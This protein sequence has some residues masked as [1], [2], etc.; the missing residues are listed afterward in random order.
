MQLILKHSFSQVLS[1]PPGQFISLSK[2]PYEV[3]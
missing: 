1:A 2:P 3:V